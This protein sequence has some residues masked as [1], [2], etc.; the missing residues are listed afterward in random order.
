MAYRSALKIPAWG[1]TPRTPSRFSRHSSP[2][3]RQEWEWASRF[4]A[5]LLQPMADACGHR[6]DIHAARY[7]TL[8]CQSERV[9]RL[10]PARRL[11]DS[12]LLLVCGFGLGLQL[13]QLAVEF[14]NRGLKRRDFG[15]RGGEIAPGAGDLVLRLARKLRER[16]LKKL[17][18]GL[19][20][21]GAA[22]HLLFSR[23][24]FEPADVLCICR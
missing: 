19:Q 9:N 16:L 8:F 4:A 12:Q 13:R 21:P 18:I 14:R 24:D 10:P 23:A 5:R 17:D 15:P 20:A 22:F 1:S 2:P 7:F 6:R 11:S 3:S